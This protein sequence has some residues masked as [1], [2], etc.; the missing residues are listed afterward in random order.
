MRERI[1]NKMPYEAIWSAV[2]QESILPLTR[3][4]GIP[5]S[6]SWLLISRSARQANLMREG[7][8]VL[9]TMYIFEETTAIG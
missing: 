7:S 9:R 5:S 8:R 6:F 3:S 2:C 4:S 1:M